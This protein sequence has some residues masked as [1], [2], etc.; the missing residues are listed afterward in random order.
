MPVG[1]QTLKGSNIYALI[2]MALYSATSLV[3]ETHVPINQDVGRCSN[4]GPR[5][6]G[7]E[8][9]AEVLMRLGNC[10]WGLL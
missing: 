5:S 7:R 8:L 1:R 9:P 6:V 4:G 10:Q 2:Q 3:I